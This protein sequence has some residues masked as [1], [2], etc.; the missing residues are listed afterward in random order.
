VDRR[1]IEIQV[2]IHSLPDAVYQFFRDYANVSFLIPNLKISPA[3]SNDP[4]VDSGV[5]EVG[6]NL[7]DL[8]IQWSSR[9]VFSDSEQTVHFRRIGGD[10]EACDG[11]LRISKIPGAALVTLRVYI[12]FGFD[13]LERFLGN[14]LKSHIH[15]RLDEALHTIKRWIEKTNPGPSKFAFLI[16]ST[17]LD[18]YEETFFHKRCEESRKPL[19]EKIF[20]WLPPFK[21]SHVYGVQSLTGKIIEGD[22]IYS[23]LTPRHILHDDPKQ[24]LDHMIEAGRLAEELGAKILGLGAYT[25]LVGRRGAQL[26]EALSIPVTT[27]TAYT[28]RAAL[29]ALLAAASAV[30]LTLKETRLAI[31]GATGTIASICSEVLAPDL[32][33]ISLIARNPVRLRDLADH[34]RKINPSLEIRIATRMDDGVRDTNLVL[35]C[36][37]TP[38][39]LLDVRVLKPGAVICDLSQPHNVSR[40]NAA[41]RKDILVIDGGVIRPPG[42]VRFNFFF[43]LPTSLAFACMAETMILA[44]EER[45][46]NYSLG[47]NITVEKVQEMGALAKKHGF[48]LGN[49]KSFGRSITSEELEIVR[50]SR[51]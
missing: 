42:N 11:E 6:L 3:D 5:L 32:G 13:G 38:D 24:T 28:I 34:L 2:P 29:D 49:L 37:S 30:G 22:L 26:A 7:G 9:V 27:G 14:E 23:P 41:L 51:S 21:A 45:F 25:A 10:L 46:E 50:N 19:L 20:S 48:S 31:V 15:D 39:V 35:L 4:P 8:L 40:E 47:G 17:D 1:G 33:A 36:T 16:H 12:N 44:L 18:L 43:G